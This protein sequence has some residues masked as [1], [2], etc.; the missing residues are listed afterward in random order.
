MGGAI[1]RALTRAGLRV[2]G[3]DA[4]HPPHGQ[5]SSHGESRIIR[6][7]YFEDPLYTPLARAAFIAWRE[8]ERETGQ[9]LLRVTGGLN[10]GPADGM[11]VAGA[12]AS[13]REHG[14]A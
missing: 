7:A 5:G 3:C 10:I 2:G 12:L 9:S 13:A 4:L 6:A 11:L 1:A 8:L 14:I